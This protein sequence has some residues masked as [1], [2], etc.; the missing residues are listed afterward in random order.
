DISDLSLAYAITIHKSQ[1]SEYPAVVIPLLT[2]H[3]VMLKRNLLYTAMT[4]G[5]QLVVLLGQRRAIEIAVRGSDDLRRT[6]K[7][8]DWLRS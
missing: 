6:T 5:K 2:E 7:L 8:A 1:G 4:R 3:F